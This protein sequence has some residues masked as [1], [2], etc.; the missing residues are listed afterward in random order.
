MKRLLGFFMA[1]V[2][3]FSLTATLAACNNDKNGEQNKAFEVKYELSDDGKYYT[4]TSFTVSDEAQ[5]AIG[6]GDYKKLAELFNTAKEDG[7][8]DFTKDT[9]KEFTVKDKIGDIPVT[10]I[11]SN[12][13]SAL[14]FIE[15]ITIPD[16]VEEIG[17]GAFSELTALKE[18]T[19]PFVGQKVGAVNS[20]VNF[21]YIFGTVEATGLTACAQ[22]YNDGT[23]EAVTYY[24]PSTL[25]TV[26]ITGGNKGNEVEKWVVKDE[27]GNL[28]EAK[29]GDEGA[30][31]IIVSENAEYSVPA[32]AFYACTT[33]EK[34]TLSGE[35]DEL[36]TNTF[37]GC[38]SLKDVSFKTEK[39]ASEAFSGC[40]AIIDID[41]DGVKTI[42]EKAFNG[43]TALGKSSSVKIHELDL[44]TVE[45]IEAYAFTGCTALVKVTLKNGVTLKD[46]AF[47]GCTS[48]KDVIGK[49]SAVI[50]GNPFHGCDK[51]DK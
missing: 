42:G 27:D 8:A 34:V 49:D 45:S 6:N 19:L 20:N 47:S 14:S 48:L 15:K 23:N 22:K 32:Y 3:T 38:T 30:Y 25:T 11:S 41:L 50:A 40:T 31:K 24:I 5:T 2:L 1:L 9:V 51:L 33:L 18:I 39:I 35:L 36:L 17:S 28:F 37:N 29:E 44:S 26:T 7:Q 12:A 10:K 13:L 16:S 43:C 4:L 46:C 21:G